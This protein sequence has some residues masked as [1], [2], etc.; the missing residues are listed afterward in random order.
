MDVTDRIY[1][2]YSEKQ[3]RGNVPHEVGELKIS[4]Q[5]KLITLKY[6]GRMDHTGSYNPIFFAYADGYF[7]LVDME[8]TNP[9]QTEI[10]PNIRFF[11]KKLKVLKSTAKFYQTDEHMVRHEIPSER[12]REPIEATIVID[13]Y[14]NTINISVKYMPDV[15]DGFGNIRPNSVVFE[16]L[17]DLKKVT[18]FN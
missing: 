11:S 14:K 4:K 6:N 15:D 8:E 16:C 9:E 5:D 2:L 3:Y 13:R 7:E 12:L 18:L 1:L 10:D 17:R